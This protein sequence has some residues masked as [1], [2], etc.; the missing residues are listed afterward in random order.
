[1]RTAAGRCRH[2]TR[3][4]IPPIEETFTPI[5]RCG[6]NNTVQLWRGR[7]MMVAGKRLTGP[8][9]LNKLFFACSFIIV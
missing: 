5:A 6:V 1:M 3:V 2:D 9:D 7:L 4:A 8:Q